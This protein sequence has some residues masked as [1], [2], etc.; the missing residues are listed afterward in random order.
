[1]TGAASPCALALLALWTSVAFAQG[2]PAA[3]IGSVRASGDL[4]LQL[5]LADGTTVKVPSDTVEQRLPSAD[6]TAAE[7]QPFEGA[8]RTVPR[9]RARLFDLDAPGAIASVR[10]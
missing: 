1:M 3:D 6:G 2:E 4:Y 7:G 8:R 10:G 9:P 5:R